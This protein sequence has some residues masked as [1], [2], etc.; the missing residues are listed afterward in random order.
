MLIHQCYLGCLSQASYV[1]ADEEAGEALIVDPRRDVAVYEAFMEERG[2]RL[3]GVA[4]THFHADFLAG[5]LELRARHGAPIYLGARAEAE[6]DFM[7]LEEGDEVA[8]GQVRIAVL[9]TPGH[10][11]E[12]VSYVVREGP[13][14]P[15]HAVLTGDTLFIGD[16]GRPDLLAS[17]GVT[18]G[19][20]AAMLHGSLHGKLMALPDDVLVYPAHGAGSLCGKNLS[21]DTVSTIGAQRT[22]N[23]ALQAPD[24]EAF[25]AMVTAEQPPAPGY[26]LHDAVL[27]KKERPL[28]EES[29]ARSLVRLDRDLARERAGAGAVLL[30]VRHEDEFH[31]GFMAGAINVGLDGRFA[32]WAGSVIAPGREI[33]VIGHAE[34]LEEAVVRLGRI[35]Y[36][37]VVGVADW[38]ALD[39]ALEDHERDRTRRVTA[40]EA[41][42]YL[43][44]SGAKIVDVRAP[45]EHR[46][47]SYPGARNA[48]LDRLTEIA[49]GWSRDEPLL[50]HCAAGYRSSCA[51][52]LLQRMGFREVVDLEGGFHPGLVGAL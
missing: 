37:S 22:G 27:N 49:E 36:D 14:A 30:D 40:E 26:F 44:E 35:G 11:P 38:E 52:S 24:V 41:P 50:V 17:V 19:E 33:V 7:P 21:S 46:A 12:S 39:G 45:G 25:V 9:E 8:V 42:G 32:P 2:L 51:V 3:V 18:S 29:C 34:R 47:A 15:P 48:P 28:L 10:T 13:D 4:L 5:H 1:I 31:G 16:V 23:A 20:L 43:A 6:F